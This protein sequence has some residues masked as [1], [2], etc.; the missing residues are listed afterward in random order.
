MIGYIFVRL[1]FGMARYARTFLQSHSQK[2]IQSYALRKFFACRHGYDS[3][4]S[5]YAAIHML[6]GAELLI[7]FKNQFFCRKSM[8]NQFPL[9]CID[10]ENSVRRLI[11]GVNFRSAKNADF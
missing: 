3:C 1:G 10:L 2:H 8:L 4:G 6:F 7:G 9:H 5:H 11:A